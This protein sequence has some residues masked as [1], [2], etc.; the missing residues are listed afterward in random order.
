M[1]SSSFCI[2]QLNKVTQMRTNKG[3][4]FRAWN[5]KGVSHHDLA[6]RLKGWQGSESALQWKEMGA[7]SMPRFEII[8]MREQE[9]A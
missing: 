9:A 4:F 8:G 3:Y 2:M 1:V 5:I 7:S 6:F